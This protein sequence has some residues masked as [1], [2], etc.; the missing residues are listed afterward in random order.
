MVSTL[1]LAG[2]LDTVTELAGLALDLD[3]VMK[4][5]LESGTVEDTITRREVVVD[6]EFVLGSGLSSSGLNLHEGRKTS[7]SLLR[8]WLSKAVLATDHDE[9]LETGTRAGVLRRWS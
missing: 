8:M 6:N 3:T 9:E 1:T 2:D 5:L 7:V 4:V